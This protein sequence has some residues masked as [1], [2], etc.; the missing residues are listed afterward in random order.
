M[1]QSAIPT[2]GNWTVSP[3][4][5]GSPARHLIYPGGLS[6]YRRGETRRTPGISAGLR[7]R[8]TAKVENAPWLTGDLSSA[9]ILVSIYRLSAIVAAMKFFP[10]LI[11]LAMLPPLTVRADPPA[12]TAPATV[13]ARVVGVHDGDSITVLIGKTQVKVRLEG[14]DAPEKGQAFSDASKAALAALVT[15]RTVQIAVRVRDVVAEVVGLSVGNARLHAAAGHPDGEA[16]RVVI[17]AVIFFGQIPL[18]ISGAAEF[19]GPDHEGV[20]EHTAALEVHDERGAALVD[21]PALGLVLTGEIVVGVPAAV[22]DLNIAHA[23][24]GESPRIEAAGGEGA[25]LA[26]ILAVEGEGFIAFA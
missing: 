7:Q 8:R 12:A 5:R 23:A 1:E 24:L 13:A 16:A 26:G 20:I 25:G 19:A 18:T 2:I 11:A 15:G 14:I 22:E 3:S 6:G 9:E 4:T 21:V 10:A 17:A